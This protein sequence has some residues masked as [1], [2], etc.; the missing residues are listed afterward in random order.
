MNKIIFIADYFS[1][2]IAGGGELNNDE[3][4]NI[5]NNL[6]YNIQKINSRNCSYDY[7][8]SNKDC[9]FIVANFVQLHK[10][11]I[12]FITNNCKYIIYE[13]DHKYLI[14]RNP[15]I[16]PN[17]IAPKNQIINESF[18]TKAVAVLCQSI[19]HKNIIKNNLENVNL[20]N[21]GGNIWPVNTLNM[22]E[23]LCNNSKEDTCAIM[24]SNNWHKNTAGAIKYCEVKNLPYKLIPNLKYEDFLQELSKNKKLVFFPQTPETLSRLVVES[25]MLNLSVIINDKVGASYEDWFNIKGIELIKLMKDKR[26]SITKTV[27]ELM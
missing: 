20:I 15:A 26:I 19:F 23:N 22:L 9:F 6:G 17:Y 12:E 27:Q 8:K 18:Y 21:L 16:F 25:R 10:A 7:V 1:N 13:H 24:E 5:L 11:C 14:T 3:L 2:E 4:I